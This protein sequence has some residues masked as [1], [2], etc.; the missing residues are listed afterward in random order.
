VRHPHT[1]AFFAFTALVVL[2]SAITLGGGQSVA[3]GAPDGM[4]AVPDADRPALG[5]QDSPAVM[6]VFTDYQCRYCKRF[7][8]ERLPAL[9]ERYVD[10]GRLRVVVRD[11]PLRKH[12]Q[13]RPAAA[14]AACAARQDRYWPMH[15]A[16]YARQDTLDTI[17]LTD[18]ARELD[19][20]VALFGACLKDPAVQSQI[21]DDLASAK[22]ARVAGTPAF[23]IGKPESGRITG[24]VF[25]GFQPITVYEA[26]IREYAPLADSG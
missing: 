14:A 15:E 13:A 17:D 16:L 24:R 3:V 19:L 7:F 26:E 11:M 20:D 1:R 22:A 2:A 25:T 21:D 9:K 5:A 6:V 10:S 4:A 8:E 23:L 12:K 18:L